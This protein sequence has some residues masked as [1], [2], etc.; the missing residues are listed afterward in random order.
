M[1]QLPPGTHVEL[2]PDECAL[3]TYAPPT[4][5]LVIAVHAAALRAPA[6]GLTLAVTLDGDEID[7][8]GAIDERMVARVAGSDP[9]VRVQLAASLLYGEDL[10]RL[11]WP[12]ELINDP[13]RRPHHTVY[14]GRRPWVVLGELPV[15]DL[16]IAPLNSDTHGAK[17]FTPVIARAD[18]R[19][20]GSTSDAILELAHLWSVP[21]EVKLDGCIAEGAERPV[22]D[23]V[24][25]YFSP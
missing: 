25:R 21:P 22:E 13:R 3:L 20:G 7:W 16:L 8:V 17:W 23:A 15:G 9:D 10:W 5:E 11:A 18:I 6:H 1:A 2:R 4:V 24:M 14:N 12:G 19:F